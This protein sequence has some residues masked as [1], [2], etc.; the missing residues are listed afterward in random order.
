MSLD[1]LI[2][3]TLLGYVALALGFVFIGSN[4]GGAIVP[5][6]ATAVASRPGGS[7]RQALFVI[8]AALLA[9]VL[10][11]VWA[12]VLTLEGGASLTAAPAALFATSANLAVGAFVGR[13][14]ASGAFG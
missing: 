12:L 7:W 13:G 4:L 1:R 11:L 6:V 9:L 10:P 14:L 5:L 3:G 2:R 8:A